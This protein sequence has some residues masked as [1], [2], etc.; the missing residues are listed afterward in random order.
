MTTK[1][2]SSLISAKKF[3]LLQ[4]LSKRFKAKKVQNASEKPLE[5]FCKSGDEMALGLGKLLGSSPG[6]DTT[7][8][9]TKIDEVSRMDCLFCFQL[10][11]ILS[12][13]IPQGNL[14][15]RPT[16]S[17]NQDEFEVLFKRVNR[18]DE[19]IYEVKVAEKDG[20]IRK[21]N[22]VLVVLGSVSN[23]STS[24]VD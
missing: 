12:Y 20:S 24:I 3:P 23:H 7:V 16:F 14:A 18:E 15:S 22:Y 21:F 8:T 5:A 4:S 9:L 13:P 11:T 6:Q 17:L 10:F 2:T 1:T 19:G